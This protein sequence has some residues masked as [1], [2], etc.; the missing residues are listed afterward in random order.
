MMATNPECAN[1]VTFLQFLCITAQ[2]I[3]TLKHNV[4]A[5]KIPLRQ[6]F[7]LISLFFVTSVA[8]NYVY[9][10][11]VPSTLHMIIRSAASPTSMF[12]CWFVKNRVPKVNSILGSIIISCG[13]A[14][15]MYGGAKVVEEE[16]K[17]LHW[18]AGV[19]ILLATLITGAFTG[20]QQE[21]LYSEYGKCPEEML[22]YTH[23]IPL[24]M[25]SVVLPQMLTIA[26]SLSTSI[27]SILILNIF[28]Q[29]YCAHSVHVLGTKET[30][31]TVT[32]ILTVRKFLSLL[33]SSIVFKNS[34]T[35]YHVIGTVLVVVG[36]YLYFDF[37][38]KKLQQPIT[39]KNK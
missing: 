34:L 19:L 17:F 6:Y 11:H 10:L 31:V 26:G 24:P 33:I 39:Y 8:N 29:F 7:F 20:L 28:A 12:V 1:L 25:F 32:F 23:A 4:F 18:C 27:W 2:G 35:M 37:F 14:I 3:L 9:A 30:S 36:T 38:S 13:V 16:I 22:F 15:A 21:R 5:P